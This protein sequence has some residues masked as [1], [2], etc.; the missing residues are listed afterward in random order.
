LCQSGGARGGDF[1]ATAAVTG[2]TFMPMA[3]GQARNTL[4]ECGD[5]Q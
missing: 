3:P 5:R 1:P 2:S 4:K